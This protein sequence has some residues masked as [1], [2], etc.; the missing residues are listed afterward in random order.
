MHFIY[1]VD[2]GIF[3]IVSGRDYDDR[4]YQHGDFINVYG[5]Y[6][7]KNQLRNGRFIFTRY[8]EGRDEED[9]PD[10]DFMVNQSF[11]FDDVEIVY[12]EMA[13][14]MRRKNGGKPLAWTS[15][16]TAMHPPHCNWITVNGIDRDIKVRRLVPPGKRTVTEDLL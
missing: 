2:L 4:G 1:S 13:W 12:D 16:T 10:Y 8:F 5:R 9:H 14:V 15:P 6:R 11:E 3:I 7:Q